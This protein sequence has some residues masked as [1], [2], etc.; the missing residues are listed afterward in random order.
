MA[1]L[2]PQDTE[3]II[4]R[5]KEEADAKARYKIEVHFGHKR[6]ISSLIPNAGCLT[7]WESGKQF[8]GGGDDKMYW[9]GYPD[10]Q[11][12]F[13]S[14]NFAYNHVVCPH[15][16]K[17]QFLDPAGKKQ[18]VQYLK[19][20]GRPLNNLDKLPMV[21]GELFFKLSNPKI[22][23]LLVKT[24]RQ[25]DSNADLYLKF[26]PFDIRFDKD[27]PGDVTKQLLNARAKRDPVIYPLARIIKDSATGSDLGFRFLALLT[28]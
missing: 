21:T 24:F 10:C 22:A 8:H 11:R 2:I 25:L 5:A 6:S 17:E 7:I 13:S 23:D 12:P 19:K 20:E 1:I 14:E 26:H 15:C 18:H 28:V 4:Q 27:N 16:Q 9:C 3:K